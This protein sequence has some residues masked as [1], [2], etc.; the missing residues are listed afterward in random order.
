MWITPLIE[1]A[2][3]VT[4]TFKSFAP[5]QGPKNRLWRS[6]GRV[7]PAPVGMRP[8][9]TTFVEFAASNLTRTGVLGGK[10]LQHDEERFYPAL[11]AS[12]PSFQSGRGPSD[13]NRQHA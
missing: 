10:R 7:M 6:I 3:V 5:R 11:E 12:A 1:E 8:A 9:S 2:A 13:R 4:S